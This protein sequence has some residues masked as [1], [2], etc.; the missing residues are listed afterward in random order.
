MKSML[1][2]TSS[3]ENIMKIMIIRMLINELLVIINVP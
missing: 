1:V 3:S 2:P